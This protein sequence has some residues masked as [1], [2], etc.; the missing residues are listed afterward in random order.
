M[1]DPRETMI[2]YWLQTAMPFGSSGGL[3]GSLGQPVA[4]PWDDPPPTTSRPPVIPAD[5]SGLLS[6]L[7]SMP[8]ASAWNPSSLPLLPTPVGANAGFP[9][10]S[11][12]PALDWRNDPQPATYVQ[13]PTGPMT[14]PDL[15]AL[16]S[17]LSPAPP[18]LPPAAPPEHLSS[19][20]YWPAAS[21]PA[22]A[23][24]QPPAY[25][26]PFPPVP[27]APTWLPV[28][29]HPANSAASGISQPSSPASWPTPASL[30]KHL[31]SAQ[32]WPAARARSGGNEQSAAYGLHLSPSRRAQNWG[33]VPTQLADT[34]VFPPRAGQPRSGS[35]LYDSGTNQHPLTPPRRS[36]LP[37]TDTPARRD[38]EQAQVQALYEQCMV[39]PN[40][41][42]L[43]SNGWSICT[44]GGI[45]P[46]AD[47][48]TGGST[49][50]FD[51][52]F[53]ARSPN[54]EYSGYSS[55]YW[56]STT[57]DGRVSIQMGI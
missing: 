52:P 26:F 45:E 7:S 43:D 6:L 13:M 34:E 35:W 38:P 19:G 33:A 12:Q 23:D 41:N 42:K 37:F 56:V 1:K 22:G 27:Q 39:S 28:P 5:L 25:A 8:P 15:S 50:I 24:E 10:P 53:Y 9:A 20:K 51:G 14:S 21:V 30:P 49:Y 48:S 55:D 29:T 32:Y 17:L 11:A 54:G 16:L 47:P 57:P 4:E 40:S 31:D 18:A 46:Q 44:Y 36:A 2:S 3:L